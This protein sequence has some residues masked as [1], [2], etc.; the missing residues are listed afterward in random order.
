MHQFSS[1]VVKQSG[2]DVFA[3]KINRASGEIIGGEIIGLDAN[4]LV[5]LVES[6]EFKSDIIEEI[7]IG[8]LALVTRSVA[9]SEACNVLVRKRNYDVDNATNCLSVVLEEF[10]IRKI[11]HNSEGNAIAFKWFN[12][13]KSKMYLRNFNTSINDFKI[14]AN[15]YL[16]AK[17]TLFITEDQDL[18]KAVKLLGNPVEVRIV[19]EAS[20]LNEFQIK[21]F[22]KQSFKEKSRGGRK[23]WKRR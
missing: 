14:I 10:N 1:T 6:S 19:G 23:Y 20:H 18:E 2:N 12:E 11:E 4:V 9:L 8:T 22:F 7:N 16:N 21:R 15:L 13:V 17:I 5:D 3:Y